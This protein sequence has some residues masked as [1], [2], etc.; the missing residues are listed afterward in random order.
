MGYLWTG[1]RVS[2]VRYVLRVVGQA[3]SACATYVDDRP[4][5]A[6]TVEEM[7]LAD[8]TCG[9]AWDELSAWLSSTCTAERC[10]WN[11]RAQDHAPGQQASRGARDSSDGC[12]H[13]QRNNTAG[14][15]Q[16]TTARAGTRLFVRRGR[17]GRTVRWAAGERGGRRLGRASRAQQQALSR[18]VLCAGESVG[19][20]AR[21]PVTTC[22]GG[23][24]LVVVVG[25]GVVD[26]V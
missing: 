7:S 19:G 21:R 15:E 18:G 4:T 24:V 20:A 17:A 9:E 23:V 2:K 3:G 11:W 12:T 26:D 5:G 1:G 22:R 8:T 16:A 6:T 13:Q 14:Q 10:P 25:V